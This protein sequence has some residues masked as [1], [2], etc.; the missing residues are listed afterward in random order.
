MFITFELFNQTHYIKLLK[1]LD[2][3]WIK[4]FRDVFF[5]K[6]YNSSVKN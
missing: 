2:A 1:T 3:A 5:C 6:N 4:L